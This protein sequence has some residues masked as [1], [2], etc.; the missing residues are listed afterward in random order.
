[1]LS[2]AE[3]NLGWSGGSHSLAAFDG[4][5]ERRWIKGQGRGY[6]KQC[7][8]ALDPEQAR[9]T[10]VGASCVMDELATRAFPKFAPP[11]QRLHHSVCKSLIPALV[12]G[13]D[14]LRLRVAR[15]R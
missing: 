14:R 6:C 11:V 7:Y 15:F 13:V 5:R 10:Y 3:R 8:A 1:M 4:V 9:R 2:W 12:L